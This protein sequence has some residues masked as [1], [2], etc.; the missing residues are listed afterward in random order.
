M[1]YPENSAEENKKRN[2]CY[3]E[4]Y[5]CVFLPGYILRVKRC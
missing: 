1:K 3:S 2:V 4:I 5:L